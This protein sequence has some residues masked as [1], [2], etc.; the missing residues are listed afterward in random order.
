MENE[1]KVEAK[2]VSS[3]QCRPIRL[4]Q[5]SLRTL[6]IAITLVGIG[7]WWALRPSVVEEELSAGKLMV[8]REVQ[9]PRRAFLGK[10]N[11]PPYSA[12]WGELGGFGLGD[13]N[14]GLWQIRNEA[15]DVIVAGRCQLNEPH[16]R[17][18][19]YYPNGQKA[20]EGMMSQG[21]KSGVWRTWNEEGKQL[22]EVQY[23]A[24]RTTRLIGG[25]GGMGGM[26]SIGASHVESYESKRDGPAR[27]WYANGKPRSEGMYANNLREGRWTFYDEDGAVTAVG[28]Y[29]GDRREGEWAVLERGV[30]KKVRY[31]EGKKEAGNGTGEVFHSCED[32]FAK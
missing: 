10:F 9:S 1:R 25:M 28:Q 5:F 2:Q 32:Y 8:R 7:C 26:S 17:W 18:S 12:Q 21:A 3:R 24:Y 29:R 16:G 14:V 22:S 23:A 30:M 15:N 19:T 11:Q 13:V 20:A 6:L 4:M 27:A 31:F